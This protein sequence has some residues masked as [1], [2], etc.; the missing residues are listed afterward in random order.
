[1]EDE[2]FRRFMTQVNTKLDDILDKLSA[3]RADTDTLRG[4][5]IYGMNDSLTLSQ[6]ITKLEQQM[7]GKA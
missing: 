4:H 5:V 1:M 3:V 2:E 7:Q 6:R